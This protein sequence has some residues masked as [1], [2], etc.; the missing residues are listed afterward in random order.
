MSQ[1]PTRLHNIWRKLV[2]RKRNSPT[3]SIMNLYIL[4]QQLADNIVAIIE[5]QNQDYAQNANMP[6]QP[7][8]DAAKQQILA[9]CTS[10]IMRDR[11]IVPDSETHEPTSYPPA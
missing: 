5:K 4:A 10:L 7:L 8:T 9:M 11:I 3:L 2:T 6:Y 1:L